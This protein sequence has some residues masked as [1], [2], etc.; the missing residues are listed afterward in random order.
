MLSSRGKY[1][2]D[3][4]PNRASGPERAWLLNTAE[5]TT[6]KVRVN[7][8]WIS[9]DGA[10]LLAAVKA[11]VGVAQLPE[12]YVQEAA[13]RGELVKLHQPWSLYWREAWAVY[14]HSR[15]LSAKVRFFVDFIVSYFGKDFVLRGDFAKARG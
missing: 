6:T 10:T 1:G 8:N 15:H 11:G 13:E 3:L 5:G 12:F 7:G 4:N 14:P 9:E 2:C